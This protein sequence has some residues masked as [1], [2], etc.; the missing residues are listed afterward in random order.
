MQATTLKQSFFR[1]F[2]F[3]GL[4]ASMVACK[5]DKDPN[6]PGPDPVPNGAKLQQYTNGEDF[7]RFTYNADG[8]VQKIVLKDDNN[9]STDGTTYTVAYNAQKKISSLTGAGQKIEVE[10]QNNVM[11]RA[12]MFENGEQV[13]YTDYTFE[14]GN[15]KK[16][17]L[18]FGEP[19][20]FAPVFQYEMTY[21][22]QGNLGKT[23]I[24]MAT[25]EPDQMVQTGHSTYEYDQKT[26]PLYQHRELMTLFWQAVSK[27]NITV[28]NEFDEDQQPSD[29]FVY[30]Y[31]Y[32]SNGLPEKATVKQGLPGQEPITSQLTFTYQ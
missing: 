19:G 14:N 32:K 31:T 7:A 18:Y 24:K 30:T 12:K 4:A 21:N 29:K 17:V 20:A 2:L 1:F 11:S 8:T 15:L 3:V 9:S 27:N 10:Y 23:V 25:D 13:G 28:E 5:K 26:N 6:G 22:A 16:A